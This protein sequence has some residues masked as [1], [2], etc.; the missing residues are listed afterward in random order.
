MRIAFHAPLKAPD[1]PVPSG[2]RQMAR[3]IISALEAG[4]HDVRLASRLRTHSGTPAPQ[5][6]AQL[7]RD[8]SDEAARLLQDWSAPDGWRPDLWLTYH[9]YYKAPDLI[10]PDVAQGLAIPYCGVESSF[11]RKRRSDAWADWNALAET[12]LKRSQM[13]FFLTDI[14]RQGLAEIVA[15]HRLVAMPPFIDMAGFAPAARRSLS[16]DAPLRLVTVAMMRARAKLDSYALLAAALGNLG[17]MTWHLTIVGDGPARGDVEAL[18]APFGEQVS[19]AGEL[20]RDGVIA[21]LGAGDLFVWPGVDEA[22]GLVYLEA[23]AAGLPVVALDRRPQRSVI[24]DG[25][26]GLLSEHDAQAF[27]AAISRLGHSGDE[28]RDMAEHARSFVAGER[29]LA[30][31]SQRF[32]TA[33]DVL[34]R[35]VAPMVVDGQAFPLAGAA[36][37]RAH[38][39]G[40]MVAFWLRDDDCVAPTHALDQLLDVTQRHGAPLTLAVIPK[41]ATHALANRLDRTVGVSVATH[42]FAHLNH[43]PHGQKSAEFGAGRDAVDVADELRAGKQR[44]DTM[45]GGA[46]LPVFVPPWNRIDARWHDALAAAGYAGLSAFGLKGEA[47]GTGLV[48]LS[49]HLDIMDWQSRSGRAADDLDEELAGWIRAR[50][51]ANSDQPLG[52]LTHHLVHDA[53]AWVSLAALLEMISAHPSAMWCDAAHQLTKSAQ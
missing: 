41:L 24:L 43:A 17:D 21:A 35:P 33:F 13:Q 53:R 49:T 22:Y 25:E 36:L 32:A 15:G 11:A 9:N 52:I 40:R 23:Q 27:A 8:A 50:I 3:Q 1:H 45:L 4:G 44:L 46:L 51:D 39:R 28:R 18:F 14:D 47:A 26:T 38:D 30:A 42:G 19:F 37:D 12:A 34:M 29:D 31:A 10:G 16:A 6:L 20:D 48:P 5:V 2:D 7:K